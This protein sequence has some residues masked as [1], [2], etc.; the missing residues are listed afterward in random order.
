MGD[1]RLDWVCWVYLESS[2][3]LRDKYCTVWTYM[4]CLLWE[5]YFGRVESQ[6]ELLWNIEY[7]SRILLP[8][9][10]PFARFCH[11]L[12]FPSYLYKAY[13]ANDTRPAGRRT[14]NIRQRSTLEPFEAVERA[15]SS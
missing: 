12:L 15:A 6:C 11:L 14:E 10:H 13:I 4:T 2:I 9:D 1:I 3:E 5:V 7:G 8:L